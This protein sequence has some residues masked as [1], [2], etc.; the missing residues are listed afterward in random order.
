MRTVIISGASSGIGRATAMRFAA[1]GDYVVNLDLKPPEPDDCTPGVWRCV[2]VAH[3]AAVRG[4]VAEANRETGRLDIVIA[5]AGISIRHDVLTIEEKDAR[6]ITDVNL[7]V[8]LGRE[9]PL[10][11]AYESIFGQPL[12]FT[13]QAAVVA[14]TIHAVPLLVKSARAAL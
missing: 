5:N 2:D 10:G 14:A 11:R 12:V 4:A 8:V 7:L 1:A 13:W 3:W 6:R 9:S